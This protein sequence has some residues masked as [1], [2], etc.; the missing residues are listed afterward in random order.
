M[1]VSSPGPGAY[2]EQMRR[3]SRWHARG[4]D[5]LD[6]FGIPRRADGLEYTIAERITLLGEKGGVPKV[7]RRR[8]ME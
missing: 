5:A 6:A 8:G 1:S 2:E 4:H 3:I 7:E